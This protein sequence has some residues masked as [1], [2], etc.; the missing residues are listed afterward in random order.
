M[1]RS[2]SLQELRSLFLRFGLAPPA[3][4]AVGL[5]TGCGDKGDE[6][7]DDSGEPLCQ[8]ATDL[9]YEGM[10]AEVY[11]DLIDY[12]EAS[13]LVASEK[14]LLKECLHDKYVDSEREALLEQFEGASEDELQSLL[15]EL[16]D[17]CGGGGDDGDGTH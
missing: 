1:S 2:A 14:E 12:V 3:M 5:A 9:G 7:E 13:D 4:L 6:D 15:A 11:C 16:L 17:Q 8:E 10:S